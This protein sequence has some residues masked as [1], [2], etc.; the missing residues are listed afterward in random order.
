MQHTVYCR[1][2]SYLNYFSIIDKHIM[3]V[4]D[5]HRHVAEL[6]REIDLYKFIVLL[7]WFGMLY[8]DDKCQVACNTNI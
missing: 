3:V 4:L 1:R 7:E 8:L 2:V 6:N 5:R